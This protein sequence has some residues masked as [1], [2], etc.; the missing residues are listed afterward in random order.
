[1]PVVR[2]SSPVLNARAAALAVLQAVLSRRRPLEEAVEE[3][4]AWPELSPRDRAFARLLVATTL[5]RL[6]RID[7]LIEACLAHPL[8]SSLAVTRDVLRLGV[9]QIVFLETPPHAAVDSA[10]ALAPAAGK[11]LVNAVLRRLTR[12]GHAHAAAQDPVRHDVPDWLWRSWTTA[13]GLDQARAIA[14][15]SLA[16]APLD[17]S[18]TVMSQAPL[19]AE[20][21]GGH[22]LPT[23][24]VR[25]RAGGSVEALPGF[26]EGAWWAQDAAAALPVQLLGAETGR[27]IVDLCAA[28]GGKTAQLAAAGARVW[29][30][31]S[32]RRRLDRLSANLKRLRLA[33]TVTV[34]YAD[35]TTWQPPELVDAVL[36]DAPCSATGTVRRHPDVL[37]LKRPKD[38]VALAALQGRL[39]AAAAAMLKP[40]G[41]LVYSVCSL[42][43]AEG[44]ERIAAA[45]ADG[46]PLAR[47]PNVGAPAMLAP[48]LTAAGALRTLPCQWAEIGGMD[49]FYA[50]RL[51]R[52]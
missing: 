3:T 41:V 4:T 49:A 21:L 45:L 6:G 14:E 22:V 13:Y 33:E 18:V 11:G 42:E 29:A 10:V 35:A 34:V 50:E 52:R 23:G 8:G 38:V 48:F 16:E 20:R 37:R 9:C 39:L 19:W 46:L 17:V 2:S 24:T 47:A 32:S 51:V 36:L 27:T 43:S 40:G 26:T 30:V 25:C 5:R 15:A 31:D 1:M 7:A 44:P 28:P 12:E